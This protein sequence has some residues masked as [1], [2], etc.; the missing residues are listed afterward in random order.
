MTLE[1]PGS[2]NSRVLQSLQA[3]ADVCWLTQTES[4]VNKKKTGVCPS[5]PCLRSIKHTEPHIVCEYSPKGMKNTH[6]VENS[7]W[8]QLR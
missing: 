3:P 6:T 7:D 5:A 1:A 2:A 4:I 8:N